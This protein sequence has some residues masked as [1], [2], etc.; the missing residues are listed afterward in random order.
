MSTLGMVQLLFAALALVMV[1]LGLSLEVA[2]F[3]R[4]LSEKR[5]VVVALVLQ[6]LILPAAALGLATA[7]HLPTPYAVGLMLLAAAPGSVSSNLYSQVF[8]GNVALNV[9]LTGINTLFS[10]ITLPLI[11]SW[12]LVHFAAGPETMPA[13]ASKLS[14]AMATVI[15]PVVIGML[16]RA[17]APR[18]AERLNKP[19]R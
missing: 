19:M 11:C 3:R 1:G 7:M 14:E 10:M 12:S 8:G 17:R 5:A 6:M 16:V 15:V 4:L 13:V 9:S 2:D 18:F